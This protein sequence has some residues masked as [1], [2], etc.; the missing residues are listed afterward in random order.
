MPQWTKD[1]TAVFDMAEKVGDGRGSR[2]T[3]DLRHKSRRSHT[4]GRF[5]L[6][7]TNG[8]TTLQAARIRL[9]LR[10]AELVDCN[11]ALGRAHFQLGQID[12]AV[13]ALARGVERASDR[14]AQGKIIEEAAKL[15]GV[16]ET[17]A[18]PSSR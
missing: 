15:E 12:E 4:L 17:I 1:H 16:L 7:F 10:D 2:L 5:R 14:L 13:A 8:P 3:V 18:D 9:D 6:S 11:I